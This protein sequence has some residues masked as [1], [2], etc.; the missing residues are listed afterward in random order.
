MTLPEWVDPSSPDDPRA[1]GA[2]EE[3]L[4]T[5]GTTDAQ[6]ASK[7][8]LEW[9]HEDWAR[10]VAGSTIDP[11]AEVR[12]AAVEAERPAPQGGAG[13]GDGPVP[14]E[15]GGAAA[16]VEGEH[17]EPD[18]GPETPIVDIRLPEEDGFGAG[19]GSGD[20]DGEEAWW[21]PPLALLA[22]QDE[23]AGA[24]PAITLGPDGWDGS[25]VEPALDPALD[26][27]LQR[28]RDEP[29][30]WAGVTAGEEAT[31]EE[32]ERPWDEPPDLAVVAPAG[33]EATVEEAERPGDEP[34]DL[35][36]VADDR[37]WDDEAE[38][39]RR[40]A[41]WAGEQPPVPQGR[42]F[43]ASAAAPAG[44]VADEVD[45]AVEAPLDWPPSRDPDPSSPPLAATGELAP[46]S[47]EWRPEEHARVPRRPP[48]M[49]RPI[50][51]GRPP[52]A[53]RVVDEES[54]R[55]RAAVGLLMLAVTLGVVLAAVITAGFLAIGFA[56]RQLSA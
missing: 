47:P 55:F 12:S 7:P 36:T 52:R 51:A 39:E 54:H 28:S 45:D 13:E 23:A 27:A 53:E 18:E 50:L 20:A 49:P 30:E 33:E 21:D 34:P 38:F 14:A 9:T 26:L 29:P 42:I 4:P 46:V 32:A 35:T 40:A 19:A 5:P 44:A 41:V 17:G 31:V 11:G 43:G 15:G 1:G 6:L 37:P 10:W 16:D 3:G 24:G 22:D 25:V 48:A 2:N 56:L 8:V